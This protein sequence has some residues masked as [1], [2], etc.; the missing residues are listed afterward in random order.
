MPD[1]LGNDQRKVNKDTDDE[2][3]ITGK[4]DPTTPWYPFSELH[5]CYNLVALDEGD[6]Q[7]LK[8]YVSDERVCRDVLLNDAHLCL[9]YRAIHRENK[10]GGR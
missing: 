1:Y 6:I 7:I 4:H 10:S 3:K 2:E 5:C 8:T 9:G